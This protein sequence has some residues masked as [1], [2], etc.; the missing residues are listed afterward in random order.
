MAASELGRCWWALG[1]PLLTEYH[2]NEWGRPV[3]DDT[4][5]F[6]MLTLEGFQAGLSWLTILRK[7]DAFRAAFA[8]FDPIAVA[9]FTDTDR[10]RL[11]GDAGIVRNRAKIDATI[12]N[13][14]AFLAVAQ[15]DGSFA[16]FLNKR[17]PPPPERLPRDAISGA[18]PATTPGSDALSA[19]SRSW[20]SDSWD[21]R[22]S[23]RSCRPL[24]SSTTTFRVASAMPENAAHSSAG[25]GGGQLGTA[26]ILGSGSRGRLIR[27]LG[28]I[29]RGFHFVT[30]HADHRQDGAP[31]G[32]HHADCRDRDEHAGDAGNGT[33]SRDR[34]QDNSWMNVNRSRVDHRGND[35]ALNDVEHHGP[36]EHDDD[37]EWRSDAESYQESDPG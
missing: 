11:M 5:L 21:R 32:G 20:A 36:G 18:L 33:A 24:A 16:A 3:S 30:A 27:C 37:R 23:T 8:G 10:A 12:G 14:A 28:A 17:F 19:N 35:V 29:V 22:S 31:R 13:A 6:E 9:A 4:H 7:R 15:R 25:S 1:D 34:Q 26:E 2:D